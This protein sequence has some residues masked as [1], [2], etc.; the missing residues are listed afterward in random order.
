M[1]QTAI[2]WPMLAHVLLVFIVYLVLAVRRTEAVRSRGAPVSAYRQRATEPESSM[3]AANNLMNQFEA[4]VLLHVACLAFHA[5]GAVSPVALALAWLFVASRYV[6]A[7]I[8]LTTN[9]LKHRSYSFR[10]GVAL[11]ALLWIWFALKLS[12]I[13]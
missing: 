9:K 12:G 2:F 13:A 1:S 3:T 4:P 8:H 5:I 10:V 7:F 6:H 11:L